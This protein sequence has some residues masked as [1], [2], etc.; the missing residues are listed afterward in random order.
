[1][2]INNDRLKPG[3]KLLDAADASGD[4]TDTDVNILEMGPDT[5]CSLHIKSP[6]GTRAGTVSIR[7]SNTKDEE[8]SNWPTIAWVDD[9]GA[10]VSSI[11]VTAAAELDYFVDLKT[12]ARFVCATFADSA[13][14]SGTLTVIASKSGRGR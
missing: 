3:G 7:V 8:V 6:S 11:A 4:I 10:M 14:G 2:A 13:A 5:Q 12:S 1:M 9:T